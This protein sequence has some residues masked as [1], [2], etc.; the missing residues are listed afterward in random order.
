MF[1]PLLVDFTSK[2]TPATGF[3]PSKFTFPETIAFGVLNPIPR[4]NDFSSTSRSP[5]GITRIASTLYSY[6]L[7]P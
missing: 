5:S 2:V 6:N 3:P 1:E 4:T 7:A